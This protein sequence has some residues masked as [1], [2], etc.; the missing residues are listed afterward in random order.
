[1]HVTTAAGNHTAPGVHHGPTRTRQRK[2]VLHCRLR[3]PPPS[4]PTPTPTHLKTWHLGRRRRPGWAWMPKRRAWAWATAGWV[5]CCGARSLCRRGQTPTLAAHPPRRLPEPVADTLCTPQQTQAHMRC[6]HWCS[7]AKTDTLY[8]DTRQNMHRDT[9]HST[10]PPTHTTHPPQTG[11]HYIHTRHIH[12]QRHFTHT[13]L[14]PGSSR[15]THYTGP[16]PP[17]S[18]QYTPTVNATPERH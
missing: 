2:P 6:G 10:H 4:L 3:S 5:H 13:P 14:Q 15:N 8:I 11:R 18:A 17:C 12:P 16:R 9:L 1:M 7:P